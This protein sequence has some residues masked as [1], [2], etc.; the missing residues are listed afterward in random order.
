VR[1]HLINVD[2]INVDG[3]DV[4]SQ[5]VGV[6]T[7]LRSAEAARLLGVTK[8]T[9]Y[10][11]VSRG[12]VDRRTAVD[13]RTSLYDR[14]QLERLVAR[15]RRRTVT[16]RPSIDVRISSAITHLDDDR[17]TYRGHDVAALATSSTFEQV[18]ELLWSGTLPDDPIV[19]RADRA[20]L[21]SCERVVEAAVDPFARIAL[22]A[23]ALI[24]DADDRDPDAAARRLL[25][26][27]PSALG[28]SRTGPIASRLARAWSR[29]P[30]GELVAA[31]DRAL[32]LLADHE[33]ATSTL[34][35]RVAASVRSDPLSAV[36]A[37]LATVR[38]PLHG[39]ASRAAADLLE[40]ASA[41]GAA[42]TIRRRLA[43]RE[44][45]PGFGHTVYRHGDP[46][47]EP[48][49]D[50]VRELPDHAGRMADVESV[51]AEA[52]R[53]IGHLP[54][55]D[56]GLGALIHVAELPRVCPVFA[57]AR[58]AGWIAH[59]TEEVGERPVRFRGLATRVDG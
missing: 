38:G 7:Y 15:S 21:T 22:C 18:A 45:L 31:I 6:T 25:A 34:A 28:G 42:A 23:I 3:V 41:T 2:P 27:V 55:V 4:G 14:E 30:S 44:H 47:F 17:L 20:A 8:P 53:V 5:A 12:L 46:R 1:A 57:V 35:V 40:E 56:L 11:Y 37:G 54:N 19:W 52:G 36:V 59:Y 33:L 29:R 43:A 39:A 48:L 58:I 10:A 13:G 51:V 24:G 16:E 32:I 9:L 26:T 49:L 50:A